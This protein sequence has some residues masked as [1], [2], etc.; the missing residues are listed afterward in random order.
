MQLEKYIGLKYKDKG[1]DYDGLDCYG[2]VR[3]VYKNEF[4][5][6]LPSFSSDYTQDDRDR[7]EELIAQYKEGWEKIEQPEVGSIVLFRV[8]GA[9][10][11]VGII[12]NESQFIHVRENQDSVI[13]NLDSPYWKKRIVGF[14]RY[15]EKK[16]VVLNAVPHPLKTQRYTI[17]VPPNTSVSKLV[18]G[19]VK[20]YNVAPEL[21]SK[22]TVLVNTKVI[23]QS[24]WST[25]ILKEGD[26]V[27]YR[28]LPGKSAVRTLLTIAVVIYAPQLA[29]LAEFAYMGTAGA[30]I[31]GASAVYATAYAATILVGTA[32]VNAIAPIRPPTT[33]AGTD[34]GSAERQLMVNGGSNRQN[35]Y[36]AIP[37]ILGKVRVTPLLGSTNYLTYENDR[38]SYL[39]MLLVWGY[40]P[41]TIDADSYKIGDIPLTNYVDY[42]LITLDRKTEPTTEVKN[43]FDAIYGKDIT[44]V[45]VSTELVCDGN[46]E[47]ITRNYSGSQENEYA[48]DGEGQPT[49]TVIDTYLR[50]RFANAVKDQLVE[51]T[52][53]APSGFVGNISSDDITDVVVTNINSTT[54]KVT[55][56]ITKDAGTF[57]GASFKQSITLESSGTYTGTAFGLEPGPWLQAA[58]DEDVDA[59]TVALHFP[60]GLRRVKIQGD[61]AGNSYATPVNFRIEYSTDGGSVWELQEAFTIG[62]DTPKKDAFTTTRTYQF[63]SKPADMI[64]RVRRE[65]GD[66]TEDNDD[67]RYYFTSVLQS[68]TFTR[69]ANPAVDPLNT[70]L[71][72]TAFKIRATDQLNGRIEGVSA[73]VQTWCKV[74]N[75]SSW[76]DGA[77]SNPAALMR[78]VLEHPA[79]PRRITNASSQINLQQLQYFYNYCESNGFEYNSVLADTRSVL[80]VLRDICAAG[81]ASPSIVD[82]KWTVVIDEVKPNVIQ[83]F[84]PHNSWGFEATK[85]LPKKPDGLRVTFYDE[86][87]DYQE[88]EVIVYDIDKDES[89]SSLFESITLPGVT[90]K[91]LVID[92]ARWHMAQIKLRPE[93]YTINTDVEYL[94]CNRGDRV[95]V[96]HDVPIWGLGSGR[97]KNRISDTKFELDEDVPMQS[98]RQY[99]IRVRSQ[100]GDSVTRTIVAKPLDGYYR[101]IELTQSVTSTEIQAGDLFLF[102]ELNQES[103]DLVILSVEPTN[104]KS[105]RLTLV[106]YGVTSDYNIFTDYLNLTSETVFETQISNTPI[107]QLE[108][109]GDKVPQIT[110]FVSDESVM[111]RISKGVFRYNMSIGYVNASQLPSIVETVEVQYDLSSATDTTNLKSIFVPYQKGSAQIVDVDEAEEYKVRMRYIGRNGKLGIW[112]DY[113]NHTV[114]GKKNPPAEVTG[115][116]VSADKS[117]GQLFLS[118]TANSEPDTST[119]EIRTSDTGWGTES[120]ERIFYGDSTKTFSRYRANGS[121]TFYIRAVDAAGNYST[122]STSVTFTPAEVPDI[123]NLDHTYSDTAL[124]SATVTLS[125]EDVTDSE[126]DIALYE[127][128]YNGTTRT[129]KANTIILPADWVGNRTFTVVTVD[130]NGKKS[131]GYSEAITKLAP[132]PP[133]NVRTQVVDNTVMLYWSLPTRT[134]LP[135]DHVLVKRG[136]SWNSPDVI[137]GEKKG[138]FTTINESIGGNFTYWLAAVDTE[139]I[140]S[141]PTSVVVNVSEPPD[142]VFH[143]EFDSTF[144][145]TK[146]S[147]QLSDTELVLPVNTTETFE[148]HF[149]TR[150]W[151]S[152]QS[153]VDAGYPIFIQPSDNTGYYE[154]VFDFGQPLASSRVLLTYSG[155]VVAGT[156]SVIPTISLSLDNSTYV[157]YN[158]STDVFGLNFR[159]VK[160]RITVTSIPSNIGLYKLESLNV[161]LDA[162]LKNDAG[163]V[164]ALSTDSLGT[165]VNF[166]KEFIDVQSLTMTPSSTTPVI[167]VYDIK[168]TFVTGTYSVS[169]GVCTVTINNHGMITG[170]NIKLFINSGSGDTGIY[171]VTGNTSNTFTVNMS[172]ADTSGGC[173]MY[174]QSF[175]VY[176]FDTS[177]T[178]VSAKTSWAIKGY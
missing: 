49:S 169:S 69:N 34:P 1:R 23:D 96:A 86:D 13:E 175:R 150:S 95:K 4:Q 172:V 173:S 60:Q 129:V 118:W 164:D 6:D 68:V 27:D 159:Y 55:G 127:V 66:N 88:N 25:T 155:T 97:I 81:R 51:A 73:V 109:F 103:Q 149:T 57:G 131:S 106:D 12:V 141:E 101:E 126:F 39:S 107:L 79:N 117:S 65:T 112:S 85:P 3:L 147:A 82:G 38:D 111:E 105:A 176:L 36:G 70:K 154:E 166:N 136:A 24:E 145:A 98:T 16:S 8:L 178:R 93:I 47:S 138:E 90:K 134:S 100:N 167:P 22:I 156:P 114:V 56:K 92:H 18:D 165:I 71:A 143:G 37:V 58:T 108:N 31:A 87:R 52:F 161:R 19:L 137:F 15:S 135:I 80:D 153:Q 10:S 151:T 63:P 148:Q 78:Y 170:Q 50:I 75:G 5:I 144:S 125:W 123:T 11:H 104:A 89:N 84:T 9:E 102:G 116:T 177:G 142:F 158:G 35:P 157:D 64:V 160:I 163:S 26:V 42:D 146:S 17:P 14:F 162:K 130:I 132:N 83:H 168:D 45:N 94:V 59:Y 67:Y 43:Q 20:E 113:V 30:T 62:G 72:K 121:D 140:E 91:S 48:V 21:K 99:T 40:G 120:A 122:T 74:W 119:Y 110:Q 7:I 44:Q 2:L 29:G 133:T 128:S 61:G 46:P 77:T 152:P 33:G 124:T 28:A 41:L 115:F 174:P 53:N 139:G 32:L 171:T 54:R 76:V